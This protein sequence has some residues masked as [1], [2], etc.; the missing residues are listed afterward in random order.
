[1]L[2]HS[3]VAQYLA[4]F[5]VG[6]GLQLEGRIRLGGGSV[7]VLHVLPAECDARPRWSGGA[8]G[9]LT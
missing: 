5:L 9:W 6:Y 4:V 8:L 2:G 1:M 7:V 3:T